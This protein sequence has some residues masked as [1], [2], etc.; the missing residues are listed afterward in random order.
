M[1]RGLVLL[2]GLA[3]L[4]APQPALASIRDRV[5]ELEQ[6]LDSLTEEV[7]DLQEPVAEFDLFD[8]C[9]YL[10]GVTEYGSATGSSGYLFG[11][12]GR[13]RRRALAMDIRDFGRP[14]YQFLAFPSE[15]PP[16]IE[17]NEDAGQELVDN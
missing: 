2:L 16:S 9:M 7:E 4:A 1:R 10:I 14:R 6:E 15:E 5:E 17:C 13:P 3:A 8:Q 12:A 11:S